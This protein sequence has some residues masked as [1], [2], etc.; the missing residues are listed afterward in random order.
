MATTNINVRVDS[1]LKRPTP[2]A[3]TK[4]ALREYEGMKK[5]P[6]KYKRYESFDEI[7]DEVFTDE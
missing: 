7:L 1:A 4:A 5:N 3:E 2:N 6:D